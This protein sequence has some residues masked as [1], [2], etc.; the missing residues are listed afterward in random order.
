MRRVFI[1]FLVL[2]SF[3]AWA[4]DDKHPTINAGRPDFT[5][6]A[7]VIDAGLFQIETGGTF[8]TFQ[9]GH[10]LSGAEFQMRYGLSKVLELQMLLPDY[11][12][13]DHGG[14]VGFGDGSAGLKWQLGPCHGWDLAV[15]GSFS[16]PTGQREFT[17]GAFDPS[18]L[19]TW[20]RDVTEA[21][22]VSG[23]YS[24]AWPNGDGVRIPLYGASLNLTHSFSWRY[25]AFAEYAGSYQS[26]GEPS[27]LVH[28]GFKHF[29]NSR[30]QLDLHFGFGL[31]HSAPDFFVGGGFSVQF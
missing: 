1:G 11:I 16:L 29:P 31:T 8:Q 15:G 3:V 14:P 5:E 4:Q 30:E 22:N 13:F 17:S 26:Q 28:F 18:A 19:I 25:A 6:N 2:G 12:R 27:N 23:T 20:A 21:D 10:R 9:G 7:T 24:V